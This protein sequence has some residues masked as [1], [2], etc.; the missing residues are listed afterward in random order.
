VPVANQ[1][2][3]LIQRLDRIQELA[4]ALAKER[5]DTIEQQ[6]L[7]ERISR[8]ILAM[9]GALTTALEEPSGS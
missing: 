4:E 9:K 1:I 7:A 2:D 8:E 5:N 3:G 6:D